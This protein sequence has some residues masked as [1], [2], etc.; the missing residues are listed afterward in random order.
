MASFPLASAIA[1]TTVTTPRLSSADNFRD[2]A[3]TTTAYTSSNDGTL[4]TGVFYRSNA[5]T[6]S[7]ADLATVNTLGISAVFDLRTASEIASAPDVLPTGATYTNIDVL[8]AASLTGTASITSAA[9]AM[10]YMQQMNEA[11]VSDA[12]TRSQLATLFNELASV[13]G[14]AL[15]HCTAGKDRTG[16]TAAMLLSI[17]GVDS[18]TIMAD[19]LAT[20]DYTAARVAATLAAMPAAYAAIYQ[21]ML[22]VD[23]SYLQAGLDE[24]TTLYGSVDNYLKSGLGLSQ[25]TLY[26]LRAKLVEYASLPGA[27]GLSGNASRGA[28]LLLALQNSSLSGAYTAYN[29]YLQSA[30]DAGT[31]GGVENTVGGQLHAD[32]ASYLLRQPA[33]LQSALAPYADGLDLRVGQRRVWTTG[34]A[35]YLGTDGSSTAASSSEHTSGSLFGLTQRLSEQLSGYAS[36]GYGK[37][38]VGAAGASADTDLAYVATGARYGLGSLDRGA[39]LAAD[40]STGWVDYSSKRQIGGGLGAAKGDTHGN[41][42]GATLRLGYLAGLGGVQ[43]EPSV[44]LRSAHVNLHGFQE[45]GSEVAL[46]VASL[47][48]TTH[49]ALLDVKLAL[50]AT[51]AG[52]FSVQPT[53]RMSYERFLGNPGVNSEGE[54]AGYTVKQA[55]AYDSRN[56]VSGALGLAAVDGPFSAGLD[57]GLSK[58]QDSHGYSGNLHAAYRF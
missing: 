34:L 55:S 36:V 19:Y 37:G 12:N 26:V 18:A 17:A 24:I 15:F 8:G 57:L 52:A 9:A 58:A 2:V 46:D 43:V 33:L 35:S 29:Y 56:L 28:G 42:Y 41:L 22:T 45:K 39:F 11:F 16:W 10:A 40:L 32:A 13:D 30:I 14:A 7:S 25:A 4:R 21:P 23:A 51:Q 20:N 27:A 50:P 1:E 6:L 49:S 44:G 3:G 47:N 38:S 54:V 48:E 5:L 53:A 31:L